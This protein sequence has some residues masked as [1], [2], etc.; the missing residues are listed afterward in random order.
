M[1]QP[2]VD[3]GEGIQIQPRLTYR[4][5]FT[6]PNDWTQLEV[7]TRLERDPPGLKGDGTFQVLQISPEPPDDNATSTKHNLWRFRAVW[8]GTPSILPMDLISPDL[9][10][11]YEPQLEVNDLPP[12]ETVPTKWVWFTLGNPPVYLSRGGR[13]R[14]LAV[15]QGT[16]SWTSNAV[17]AFLS[18]K[19][20]AVES[21]AMPS[22]ATMARVRAA[23]DVQNSVNAKNGVS[24]QVFVPV[25][26]VV[27]ARRQVAGN[28]PKQEILPQSFG[29]Q[30][31]ITYGPVDEE[32]EVDP[33]VEELFNK[34]NGITSQGDPGLPPPGAPTTTTIQAPPVNAGKNIALAF[35]G[36]AAVGGL[37]WAYERH[38]R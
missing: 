18:T 15:C 38:R 26:F 29:L 2:L 1:Y 23:V 8:M 9:V 22:V 13:Y 16:T 3:R 20:W 33:R 32:R 17:M 28:L 7:K 14:F 34:A 5:G 24:G 36:A 37:V 4:I 31:T 30:S 10:R 11:Y 12:E 19:N 21:I 25:V 35:L 27:V 6:A